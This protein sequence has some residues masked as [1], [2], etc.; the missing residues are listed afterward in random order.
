MREW[1]SGLKYFKSPSSSVLVLYFIWKEDIENTAHFLPDCPQFK[2]NFDSIWHNL[3]MKII[4][5]NQTDDIQIADFIK[6][7]DRWYK[8]LLVGNLSL[9]LDQE[10]TALITRFVPLAVGKL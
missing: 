3:H 6:G 2:D 9:Q 10:A 1:K 7:L 5:S 4:R 8:M